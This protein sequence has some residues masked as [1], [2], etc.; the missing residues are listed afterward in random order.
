MEKTSKTEFKIFRGGARS[1][2]AYKHKDDS[3]L[4]PIKT[5][6]FKS[7]FARKSKKIHKR[8]LKKKNKHGE[9]KKISNDQYAFAY[10]NN[11]TQN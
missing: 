4:I 9:R 3:R 8:K 6:F 10:E 2:L 11:A 5:E 1:N 7:I